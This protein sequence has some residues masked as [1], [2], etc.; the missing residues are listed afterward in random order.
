MNIRVIS[1]ID[2]IHMKKIEYI[3]RR[4]LSNCLE[5]REFSFDQQ[6]LAKQLG[7][8]SSTVNLSLK[9]L[10]QLGAV[11]ISK[12]HSKVTDPEKIL[13][14]WANHRRL[15]TDL[16]SQIRVNLPI[17]EIEGRLPGDVIPTAYTAV[18]KLIGEPPSDYDKIY[19]YHPRP[20][21]VIDRFR[22]E[23][24]P[25]PANLFVL[26][27]DPLL[28]SLSLSQLFV[29]LWGLSDW[30]A[31]DF[32][33]EIRNKISE[34]IPMRH[35]QSIKPYKEPVFLFTS[36]SLRFAAWAGWYSALG[37]KKNTESWVHQAHSEWA[38]EIGACR[39][40]SFLNYRNSDLYFKLPPETLKKLV[41]QFLKSLKAEL[42]K[43]KQAKS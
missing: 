31:K 34:T 27:A 12:R 20:E 42:K 35:A 18:R 13:Y 7:L 10:R 5:N 3:W 25:G 11:S 40:Y 24:S 43:A 30:Y 15:M 21:T 36:C 41:D 4:L 2:Y 16:H 39:Q 37:D 8:S 28:K 14:H 29:D 33:D 6:A 1:N 19:C 26:Q 9:P 22:G 38:K 23:T 17:L 32:I